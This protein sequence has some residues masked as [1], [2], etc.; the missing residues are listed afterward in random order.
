M[1]E[2]QK[3]ILGENKQ[4]YMLLIFNF[5]NIFI[6]NFFHFQYIESYYE[7]KN[8][9]NI[10][11]EITNMIRLLLDEKNFEDKIFSEYLINHLD[12]YDIIEFSYEKEENSTIYIKNLMDYL[13]I[14]EKI[15]NLNYSEGSLKAKAVTLYVFFFH[16]V[17]VKVLNLRSNTYKEKYIILQ[18]EYLLKQFK[19]EEIQEKILIDL[20]ALIENKVINVNDN[21]DL[22]KDIKIIKELI[23]FYS[24][25]ELKL[26]FIGILEMV[27]KNK[28]DIEMNIIILFFLKLL[29]NEEDYIQLNKYLISKKDLFQKFLYFDKKLCNFCLKYTFTNEI[30]ILRKINNNLLIGSIANIDC[31]E[32]FFKVF[33]NLNMEID[34]NQLNINLYKF[35]KFSNKIIKLNENQKF[36]SY[37]AHFNQIKNQLNKLS[38]LKFDNLILNDTLEIFLINKLNQLYI[39]AKNELKNEFFEYIGK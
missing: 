10:S 11:E 34:I 27:S 4:K 28:K 3:I 9:T 39:S 6:Q 31:F 25:K 21:N 22:L 1:I 18:K 17:M 19:N 14:F 23:K 37:S 15:V 5:I 38:N 8:L 2:I 20:I 36:S 30:D 33:E 32:Y 12:K 16:T 7:D 35:M 29:E 24:I 26:N 13:K